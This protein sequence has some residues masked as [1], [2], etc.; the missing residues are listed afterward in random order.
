MS[1]LNFVKLNSVCDRIT[2]GSHYSP[3]GITDGL[4]MLSVKDMEHNGFSYLDCKYIS[5]EEYEKMLRNDCVPLLNDVLIAKDGSYLKHVF[6]IKEEKKQAILSSIGILRP[7]LKKISPDYLKYYL[8]SNSV[9]ETVAKKYVSGSALPRIILKNFGE[10]DIIYKP[11]LEQ[12][13]IAKVLSDLD[14]KIELNNKINAELE[15]MAKTLYDYWFVQFDFPNE[16]GKPYKSSGG[17]MVWN[18]ELKTEIPEGWEVDTLSSFINNDKSGDWGKEQE[19]GNYNQKVYCVRG[20]DINGLNGKGELKT[21]ERYILEKN[22]FKTL[23]PYDLIVE[24]SGGSPVQS[25]GRLAYITE[26][27]LHRFDAPIICSNFC[28]A[29]TLKSKYYFYNF[30]F[31]WNS[32]YDAGVLF[33][34]EGKTSGI[35]NLLFESFVSTHYTAIPPIELAEKFYDFMKPIQIKKEKNLKENQEL[36]SLR[37]WLLPMLMNGQVTVGDVKEELGMVAENKTKY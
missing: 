19:E 7:N 24:I 2:D 25:T 20:A 8:H 10:I 4:P 16:N 11:L 23:D 6:V 30:V 36:A 14:A 12:Q 17:K 31:Q 34:Y 32:I 15:A 27:T 21:P 28:K 37:D 35:K 5:E 1:N 18:E 9:K 13:K 29:V 3:V 26:E 22:L 33:G